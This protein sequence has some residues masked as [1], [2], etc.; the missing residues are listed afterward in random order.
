MRFDTAQHMRLGQQMRL[1]PRMIQSMEILQLSLPALEERIEQELESNAVL[2]LEAQAPEASLEERRDGEEERDA[3]ALDERELVVGENEGASDFARLDAMETN[4]SEAF[5]NEY[6]ASSAP[7]AEEYTPR[8]HSVARMA[9][10]RDGKMDA[11]ANTAARPPSLIEQLLDQWALSEVDDET[12]ALGEAIIASLDGDGYLRTPLETIAQRADGGLREME[13]ARWEAALHAAQRALDP[14]GVA[15]RSPRECLLL[16]LDALVADGVDADELRVERAI[17]EDHL[18]DLAQNRLP[19]IAEAL[20]TPLDDVKHA[21]ERLKHL[22]LAPGRTLVEDAPAPILPDAVI[23][24]D[25]DADVY[26]AYLN[27]GWTRRLRVNRQYANMAKD[28]TLDRPTREF[29]RR[30]LAN[31]QWLLEAVEQ[32]KNTLQRVLNVVAAAQRDFFDQGPQALKPLPMTQVAEQLGVHVAT[33]SRAVA[34][35]FVET[36]RGVMPLRRFFSGGLT[37]DD[38]E[39]M[40]W[41][42][43]KAALQDIIDSEDKNKPLSDDAIVE[44][45]KERGIEIARRTVAKYRAQ[46]DIPSAR[47]RKQF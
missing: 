47:L 16:Q 25:E 20:E 29:F 9:G 19:K 35:K 44:A 42:A 38:G 30:N 10:E 21:V 4:Y 36:P 31:A 12:R 7:K 6:S 13:E 17:V 39:D 2:E 11:M 14:P 24:Y 46:L 37:T 32:R 41:D 26:T 33:V 8:T 15:A 45:L 40:S 23:E 5:E 27:D 22:R 1:A 34:G 28:R 18:D 43:I 3:A